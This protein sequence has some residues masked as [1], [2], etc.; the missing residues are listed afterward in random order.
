MKQ[1]KEV[2]R[3]YASAAWP[4]YRRVQRTALA[5]RFAPGSREWSN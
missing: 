2:E 4:F 3:T 1:K 5:L